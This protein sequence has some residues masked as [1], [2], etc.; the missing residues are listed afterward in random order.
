MMNRLQFLQTQY[1]PV[2]VQFYAPPLQ[3]W[4]FEAIYQLGD[5][6]LTV[7]AELPALGYVAIGALGTL[8]LLAA[9]G[10]FDRP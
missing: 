3:S 8:G 1:A 9:I 7:R 5:E 2:P 6:Q 4:P 10:V